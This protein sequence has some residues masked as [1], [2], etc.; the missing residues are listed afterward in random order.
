L[1]MKFIYLLERSSYG[2]PPNPSPSTAAVT[3][4]IPLLIPND[5]KSLLGIVEI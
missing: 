2:N 5:L 4:G 3:L 1:L